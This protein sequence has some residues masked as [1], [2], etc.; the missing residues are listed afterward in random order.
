MKQSGFRLENQEIISLFTEQ[1]QI[2]NQEIR[3]L[4]IYRA[5]SD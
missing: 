1:F 2:R 4:F 5:V 3:S